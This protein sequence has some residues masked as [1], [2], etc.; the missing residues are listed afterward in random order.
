VKE[1][2]PEEAYVSQ[3]SGPDETTIGTLVNRLKESGESAFNRLSEQ[4]LE[5]PMFMAALRRAVEA[6]SQVD[7]TVSTTMDFVNLPSKNDIDRLLEELGSLG[8]QVARQQKVL[9]SI[10]QGVAQLQVTV[11]RLMP[12]GGGEPWTREH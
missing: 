6:K 1:R 7:K 5:T 8:A 3:P 2:S 9:T 12:P 11:A 4:L 10:E